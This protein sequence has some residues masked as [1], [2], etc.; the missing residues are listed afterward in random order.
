MTADKKLT[1]EVEIYRLNKARAEIKLEK[2]IEEKLTSGFY[3]AMSPFMGKKLSRKVIV[4]LKNAI[5]KT[6]Q[7]FDA[8]RVSLDTKKKKS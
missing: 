7:E 8:R 3:T 6:C 2:A 4:G 5:I 1:Y